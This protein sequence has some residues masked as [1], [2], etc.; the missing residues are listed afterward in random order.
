MFYTY[1]VALCE[2]ESLCYVNKTMHANTLNQ[3]E[4]NFGDHKKS[5]FASAIKFNYN[6]TL[7]W[8]SNTIDKN[9]E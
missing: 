2:A 8:R 3:N 6:Q 5:S 7:H 9:T 1:K 4:N